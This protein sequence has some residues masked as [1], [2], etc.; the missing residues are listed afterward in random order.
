MFYSWSQF[1][2]AKRHRLKPVKEG[3]YGTGS[4]RH[5]A[6]SCPLP[7]E[8]QRQHL[9]LTYNSQQECLT[10]CIEY[11]QPG[12]HS[13]GRVLS[14]FIRGLTR[15]QDWPPAQLTLASN[16]SRGQAD[17]TLHKVS[18]TLSATLSTQTTWG[19]QRP[20]SK[21]RPSYQARYSKGFEVTSQERSRGQTLGSWVAYSLSNW[22][23]L[24]KTTLLTP[25]LSVFSSHNLIL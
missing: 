12:E 15:R 4:R 13:W 10:A 7:A 20:S 17:T 8:L 14:I 5:Q 9:H 1:I 19:G 16:F 2:I 24:L 21:Q 23:I 25:N 18:T 22:G 11:C 3:G 6:S